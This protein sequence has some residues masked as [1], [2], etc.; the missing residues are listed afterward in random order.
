LIDKGFD[1][2]LGAGHFL[3]HRL[4]Q[5]LAITRI[6]KGREGPYLRTAASRVA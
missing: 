5:S 6:K 1:H 4:L 2:H 3:A